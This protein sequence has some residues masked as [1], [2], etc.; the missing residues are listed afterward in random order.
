[1]LCPFLCRRLAGGG[2]KAFGKH[3]PATIAMVANVFS[4]VL[5]GVVI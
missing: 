5:Y 2:G 4:D 3:A 1:M